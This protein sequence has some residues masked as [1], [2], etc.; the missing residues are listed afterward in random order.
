MARVTSF[1]AR[2]RLSLRETLLDAAAELLAIRGFAGL[3]MAD[4]AA[5]AGVSRQTVYN[6]FGGK[7]AL[8]DSVVLRTLSEFLDGTDRRMKDADDVL[9]GVHACVVYTVEHARENRLVASA[10]GATPDGDAEDLLPFLTIRGEPVLRP[11]VDQ[12]TSNLLDRIPTLPRDAAGMLAETVVRLSISH[13][14]LRTSSASAA[15]DAV[16]AVLAPAI[17][18]YSSG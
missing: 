1:S 17:E 15:A 14:L 11:S 4:V 9:S 13:L 8:V 18:H 3:R 12:L 10:I 6:E 2:L 5:A 7:P 16:C